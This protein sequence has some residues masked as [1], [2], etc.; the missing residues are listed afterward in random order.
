MGPKFDIYPN[1]VVVIGDSSMVYLECLARGN[2]QPS[3]IWYEQTSIGWKELTVESD[4]R[5][6]FSSG[7]FS[8]ENPVEVKDA[9][10]YHCKMENSFGSLI[11]VPISLSFG[12]LDQ[13]SPNTPGP[14]EA[15]LYQGTFMQCNPPTAKPA[16]TYQWY[17]DNIFNFIRPE[18]QNYQFISS[19]GNLYFSEV[20]E[21]DKGFYHCVVTLTVRP[22]DRSS[23][24]QPPSR[25]SKGI[26]LRI[27]GNRTNFSKIFS[28]N[29]QNGLI[30]KNKHS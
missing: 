15:A 20:Q 14:V 30:K 6:T 7:R 11:S 9:G 23:T 21:H 10:T 29:L 2:P 19:N 24:I 13:F 28:F 5:Y 25:T 4:T 8:I 12:Q 3:H 17:K 18:L 22:G 26:E 27:K 16:L 1:N